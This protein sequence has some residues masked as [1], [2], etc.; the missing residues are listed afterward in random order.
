VVFRPTV[1]GA[2]LA[3]KKCGCGGRRLGERA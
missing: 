1:T 2:G 3:R